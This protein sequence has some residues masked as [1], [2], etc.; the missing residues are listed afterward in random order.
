[1]QAIFLDDQFNVV[2]NLSVH[3]VRWLNW[4]LFQPL[5]EKEGREWQLLEAVTQEQVLMPIVIQ[6]K[7]FMYQ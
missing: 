6:E 1:M 7:D 3:F 5:W 2:L 4:S